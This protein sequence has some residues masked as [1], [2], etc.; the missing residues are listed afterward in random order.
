MQTLQQRVV[1]RDVRVD[2]IVLPRIWSGEL[3]GVYRFVYVLTDW[4]GAKITEKSH[5]DIQAR[6][7][8]RHGQIY[9]VSE[10]K[11]SEKFLNGFEPSRENGFFGYGNPRGF[12]RFTPLN[13]GVEEVYYDFE[14]K[15]ILDDPRGDG[16]DF[17]TF[18]A[19][20]LLR[21]SPEETMQLIK[22][23]QTTSERLK[24]WLRDSL[25]YKTTN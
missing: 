23:M 20:H 24:V 11:K 2:D 18:F 17:A 1:V 25:N 12:I 19:S 4:V 9:L 7:F 14:G 21:L 22:G 15:H 5:T 10:M 3:P 8:R 6:E 16:N 13:T